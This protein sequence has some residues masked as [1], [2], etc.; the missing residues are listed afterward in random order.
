M[1]K[2]QITVIHNQYRMVYLLDNMKIFC[3]LLF[4]CNF[5]IYIN[6]YK[7]KTVYPLCKY[8]QSYHSAV[9]ITSNFLFGVIWLYF[10][11]LPPSKYKSL[12]STCHNSSESTW[13][14]SMAEIIVVI[15]FIFN[16]RCFQTFPEI[17]QKNYQMYTHNHKS[18][19]FCKSLCI[20]YRVMK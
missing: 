9:I 8:Q 6:I 15:Y 17:R 16:E 11:F 13:F 7:W 10:N 1:H 5:L 20:F 4:Y 12:M 14:S 18:T 3:M 2:R 19:E